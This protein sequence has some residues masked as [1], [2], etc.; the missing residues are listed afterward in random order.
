MQLS[1]KQKIIP[2]FPFAFS[3]FRFNFKHFQKKDGPHT[4]YFFQLRDSE[5]RG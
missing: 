3:K 5:K 2:N 1:E 4:W